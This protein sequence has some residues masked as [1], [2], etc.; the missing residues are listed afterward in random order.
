MVEESKMKQK[1]V[2]IR[3][4]V[5]IFFFA[6]IG[7]IAIN[8]SLVETGGGIPFLSEAS[9]HGICPF[10]GV[11]SIY[12]LATLGIFIQ[13][14]HISSVIL[15]ILIFTMALLFG[16][17]FCGWICPLGSIQEWFGKLGKKIFKKRYNHFIPHKIDRVLRYI[18]YIVLIWV[19]YIT[20]RSGILIFSSIDPYNALFSF[21]TE[22][23]EITAVAVLVLTL[24]GS[25]FVERPWCK[26][27]CPYGALLGL[28]NKIRIFKIIRNKET[29]ISCHKC[30]KECPM[31]IQISQKEKISDLQCISCYECTSERQC[32]VTDTINL[33]TISIVNNQQLKISNS[34]L[35]NKEAVE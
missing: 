15:M 7:L 22:E 11:V 19:V 23:V 5:Q 1:K 8:K 31:N 28:S 6:L 35:D 17:V 24:A 32:P 20:A 27:A 21:W 25:L 9:L 30:D 3:R 12:N 34:Y 2:S 18:R 13:K 4:I 14:I 33:K 29:C 10:G 16:T 26:Y